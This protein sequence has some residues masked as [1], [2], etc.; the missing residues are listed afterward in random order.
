[1]YL[2]GLFAVAAGACSPA[3]G[4]SGVSVVGSFYPLAWAAQQIGGAA[5]SV[6]D[7]TPPGVEAHDTNLNARQV[8][9]IESADVVLLLGYLGFQPQVES[10]AQQATGD[11]V[12]LT[13]GF[14]LRSSNEQG[15]SA[16]PHVWLDPVLMARMAGRIGA[17][18]QHADP[19]ER[20]RIGRGTRAVLSQLH[21]L[22]ASYRH[23]LSSCQYST[24]VATHEAFGYMAQ[25]YGLRQLGIEGLTP[26]A[27]PSASQLRTVETAIRDGTAAPAVFYEGT[28]DGQRIGHSV[29][30]DLHVSALPLGTL[31]F[32]PTSGT[33]VTVMRH[34][35]AELKEGLRCG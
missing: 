5:V 19:A 13:H 2:S 26:E 30:S 23:G 4:G 12:Q 15:L 10:A 32:E 11:V 33:Y 27:E 20:G 34:N 21:A 9:T 6:T 16:D 28:A 22:D 17:A 8:A 25:Q 24:F 18:L 1:M 31:E 29:A 14:T 3:S 35:L 7:L